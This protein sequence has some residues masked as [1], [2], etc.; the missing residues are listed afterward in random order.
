MMNKTALIYDIF[1]S[2]VGPI[3]LVFSGKTLCEISY[4]KPSNISFKKKSA[5]V[6]FIK[7]LNDYF[8][9]IDKPFTQKIRFLEGTDFERSVWSCLKDVP[10]GE[11]RT[12]KWVAEKIGNPGAVR[13][14][15]QALSKNPVP[16]VL[17]CHR[18]IESD[19]SIG[20]YSSGQ[21]IKVRLLE[22][23]YYSTRE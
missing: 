22:M 23:E 18:I 5:P 16:I 12:Y 20:G 3:Y 17:P 14:V 19:G 13:A 11:T 2:P 9:G 15:G 7:E 21:R 10:Y 6:S 4:V 1:D 8:R